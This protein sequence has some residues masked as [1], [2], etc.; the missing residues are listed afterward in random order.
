MNRDNEFNVTIGFLMD[1]IDRLGAIVYGIT[2][3]QADLVKAVNDLARRVGQLEMST[4]RQTCTF[5]DTSGGENG[6]QE[7]GESLG[8]TADRADN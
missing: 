2:T 6:E 5:L 7:L 1:T 8:G 3:Q 4:G